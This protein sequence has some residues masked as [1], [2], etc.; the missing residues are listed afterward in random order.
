MTFAQRLKA[1]SQEID[2]HLLIPRDAVVAPVSVEQPSG[3]LYCVKKRTNKAYNKTVYFNLTEDEARLRCAALNQQEQKK[4][5]DFVSSRHNQGLEARFD[6][7]TMYDVVEQ[8]TEQENPF[9]NPKK[10]VSEENV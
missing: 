7:V 10:F 2:A 9:W 6:V 3:P 5:S 1:K 8:E 4:R